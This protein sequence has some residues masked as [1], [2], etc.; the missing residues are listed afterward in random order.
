M[1]LS[2]LLVSQGQHLGVSSPNEAGRERAWTAWQSGPGCSRERT[3]ALLDDR[4]VRHHQ[5][6]SRPR[7]ARRLSGR[8]RFETWGRV[9]EQEGIA[10][11]VVTPE[12]STTPGRSRAP[13][14]AG[15]VGQPCANVTRLL[16]R[17]RHRQ[18][19]PRRARHLETCELCIQLPT[20]RRAWAGSGR[21]CK[22]G[23][24][25]GMVTRG[26]PPRPRRDRGTVTAP[27]S[28]GPRHSPTTPPRPPVIDEL[29]PETGA[30]GGTVLSR[31]RWASPQR[32]ALATS[33]PK[34]PAPGD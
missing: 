5:N 24:C 2:F 29:E 32:P 16:V 9:G 23:R 17:R 30:L 34:E 25:R 20:S 3:D 10:R 28:D 8:G 7:P 4:R 26:G 1:A 12:M 31:S 11:V 6:F 27:R 22:G 15:Q 13:C 18:L 19:D 33:Q 21:G 14:V